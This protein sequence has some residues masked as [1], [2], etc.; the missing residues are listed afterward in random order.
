M[1]KNGFENKRQRS[2]I[3]AEKGANAS[4]KAP[5]GPLVILFVSLCLLLRS[6]G[7]T[8]FCT[9]DKLRDRLLSGGELDVHPL[10]N[11]AARATMLKDVPGSVTSN[12]VSSVANTFVGWWGRTRDALETASLLEE[13]FVIA[14]IA[15]LLLA[16]VSG[17]FFWLAA[18]AAG[19]ATEPQALR[20]RYMEFAR[21]L[22]PGLLCCLADSDVGGIATMAEL[23][24]QTGERRSKRSIY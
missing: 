11:D 7:T 5:Q 19:S 15:V 2:A 4:P 8:F 10:C 3:G 21:A 6:I 24:S 22:G 16:T 23:G 14:A 18:P 13:A 20:R 1:P 17:C 9:I 12:I